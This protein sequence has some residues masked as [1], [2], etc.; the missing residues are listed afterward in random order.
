MPNTVEGAAVPA[1]AAR[2]ADRVAADRAAADRVA[3]T[4]HRQ[5]V[6]L[7]ALQALRGRLPLTFRRG[8]RP[9]ADTRSLGAAADQPAPARQAAAPRDPQ[10]ATVPATVRMRATPIRRAPGRVMV[11]RR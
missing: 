4:R 11:E 5:A 8:H 2:K 1:E 6:P 10:P 3:G 7:A 9:T